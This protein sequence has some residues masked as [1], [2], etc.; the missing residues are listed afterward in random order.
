MSDDSSDGFE[1][2]HVAGFALV[3]LVVAGVVGLGLGFGAGVFVGKSGS[4]G[5]DSDFGSP[6]TAGQ[7]D[8]RQAYAALADSKADSMS[9]RVERFDATTRIISHAKSL[10][11]DSKPEMQLYLQNRLAENSRWM[12]NIHVV[13][14][15]TN[16]V[17]ESTEFESGTG[18]ENRPWATGFDS[19]ETV[20]EVKRTGVYEH[21]H[22]AVVAFTSPV[23]GEK[24]RYVTVT[25][26]FRKIAPATYS[27]HIDD[28]FVR[29][30]TE[31]A[32]VVAPLNGPVKRP[33]RGNRTA[34]QRVIESLDHNSD[35]VDVTTVTASE[36]G[37]ERE[38]VVAVSIV[39]ETEWYVLVH[40]PRNA[41]GT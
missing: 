29:V 3:A 20:S 36:D 22:T 39:E 5:S 10:R 30:A 9:D 15:S 38:Y 19:F 13:N 16:Q 37:S 12:L 24:Q 31:D 28:S 41:A 11:S 1:F 8:L 17:I 34:I 2:R 14:A 23:A 25:V 40:V 18:I 6:A 27:P 21:E 7:G 26:Q 33:Y 32:T 4:A 35:G